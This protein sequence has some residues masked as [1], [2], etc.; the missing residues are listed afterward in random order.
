MDRVSRGGAVM[1]ELVGEVGKPSSALAQ[2]D[3]P[4]APV[5][6][7]AA[8]HLEADTPTAVVHHEDTTLLDVLRRPAAEDGRNTS[9]VLLS[10]GTGGVGTEEALTFTPLEIRA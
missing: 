3:D 4:A 10:N 7:T 2:G 6:G 1:G 9:F 8:N 5:V